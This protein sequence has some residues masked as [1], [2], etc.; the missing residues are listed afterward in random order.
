MR[1][2][3]LRLLYKDLLIITGKTKTCFGN[4][5]KL[6]NCDTIF[7][8][9]ILNDLMGNKSGMGKNIL[10]KLQKC[11]DIN[12]IYFE[13]RI[14][15]L[16]T[17]NSTNNFGFIGGLISMSRAKGCLKLYDEVKKHLIEKIKEIDSKISQLEGTPPLMGDDVYDTVKVKQ[18]L[19][20]K[21]LDIIHST[22]SSVFDDDR[23]YNDSNLLKA[24][25]DIILKMLDDR[26]TKLEKN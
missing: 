17:T 4:E 21:S 19:L 13:K 5:N 24:K 14:E 6:I 11:F 18:N 3:R 12:I 1:N 26:L 22:S 2:I 25:T 15:K 9:G 23:C 8:G 7:G 20:S 10:N 16:N